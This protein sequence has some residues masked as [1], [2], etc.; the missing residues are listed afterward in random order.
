MLAEAVRGQLSRYTYRPPST[1]RMGFPVRVI[2]MSDRERLLA[3]L[4]AALVADRAAEREGTIL[5][6]GSLVDLDVGPPNGALRFVELLVMSDGVEL[7]RSGLQS[8][9]TT[10]AHVR[11]CFQIGLERA[12]VVK[13]H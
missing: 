7:G 11:T 6:I 5:A 9:D 4:R 13:P 3:T 2:A 12:L 1:R 8:R 10:H